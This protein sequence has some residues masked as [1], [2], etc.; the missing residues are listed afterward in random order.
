DTSAVHLRKAPPVPVD[1]FERDVELPAGIPARVAQLSDA[2]TAHQPTEYDKVAAVRDYLANNYRY[3]L[4]TPRLP[5]GADATDQFLFND[6]VGFCEQ[7]ATALA[8]LVRQ[9]GI[10][11]RLA[12]GYAQGEHDSLTGSFT[13]RA[14]DAHAWVEIYFP[15][16]GWVP[17]DASP[18]YAAMPV[19]QRPPR[20]F[21]SDVSAAF[22]LTGVAGVPAGPIG[23]IALAAG[24][25]GML[26]ALTTR[27][28][29]RAQPLPVRRYLRAL[30]LVRVAGLPTRAPAE[31]PRAHQSRILEISSEI[32]RA[33]APH[34]RA[35][36]AFA[37]AP[38]RPT[39]GPPTRGLLWAAFRYR[40]RRR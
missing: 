28:K 29:R 26:L 36:E 30:V 21:L 31:T 12:I 39:H 9:A 33:L 34:S 3:S 6:R 18:G 19:A 35:V 5:T 16:T 10:P 40:L 20:W 15:G 1:G 22:S 14:R 38:P 13:V 4:D 11:A 27:R 17:F 25:A 2:L 24:I 32:G 37:Y 7:F 8:V 23:G